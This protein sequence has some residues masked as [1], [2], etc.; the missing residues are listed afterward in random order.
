M[1][2]HFEPGIRFAL[3]CPAG[4]VDEGGHEE[5]LQENDDQNGNKRRKVNARSLERDVPSNSP[6]HRVGEPGKAIGQGMKERAWPE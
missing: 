4:Q 3:L 1:K 2:R 6:E 5:T